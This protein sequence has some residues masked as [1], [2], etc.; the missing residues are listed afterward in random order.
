VSDVR[1]ERGIVVGN[2]YDKLGTRNPIARALVRGFMASFD[3]LLAESGAQDVHEVGCGEG[4]LAARLLARGLI[5]RGSDFS[6]TIIAE[7]RHRHGAAGIRFDVK[8]IYHLAPDVDAA[9]LVVCCEVLEHL[10]DPERA[11]ARL[12]TIV[13][14]WCI[15]SVPREPIWKLMNL[16]RGR[17]WSDWGNT[18]GHVQ[19]W[20]SRSFLALVERHFDVV[21]VRR[22]LPW[23]MVLCRSRRT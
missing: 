13:R 16:A 21:T 20:S 3:A 18:P 6:A 8:S 12:A 9:S 17:Y 23:T 4:S 11:L 14:D 5:V 19:R 7:A 15:L 22:P 10:H 1:T 2:V